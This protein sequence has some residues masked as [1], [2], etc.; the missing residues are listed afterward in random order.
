M[1]AIYYHHPTKPVKKL[2]NTPIEKENPEVPSEVPAKQPY[3]KKYYNR[4]YNQVETK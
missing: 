4:P 3:K 1:E 2:Y